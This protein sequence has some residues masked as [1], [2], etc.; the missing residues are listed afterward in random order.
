MGR[1]SRLLVSLKGNF[2]ISG[3]RFF[4]ENSKYFN[5]HLHIVSR[6]FTEIF[7]QG[8]NSYVNR[9][10]LFAVCILMSQRSWGFYFGAHFYQRKPIY[11][12]VPVEIEHETYAIAEFPFQLQS[13]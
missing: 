7:N 9:N 4:F 5:T 2:G 11:P 1:S 10:I 12:K 3:R 6:G 13:N 8:F